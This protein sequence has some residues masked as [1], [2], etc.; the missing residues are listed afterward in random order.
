MTPIVSIHRLSEERA[1]AEEFHRAICL[2]HLGDTSELGARIF[3]L[4]F[5]LAR[6]LFVPKGIRFVTRDSSGLSGYDLEGRQI[7]RGSPEAIAAWLG[8]GAGLPDGLPREDAIVISDRAGVLGW[9]DLSPGPGLRAQPLHG[10][11]RHAAASAPVETDDGLR[12]LSS[13]IAM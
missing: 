2:C 11:I 6:K 10:S 1:T 8:G 7:R 4:A 3:D 13:P 12:D 9:I 5:L